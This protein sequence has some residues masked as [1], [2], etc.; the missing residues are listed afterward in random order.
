M[1]KLNRVNRDTH[2]THITFFL[3]K[4]K[5]QIK[6]SRKKTDSYPEQK[7]HFSNDVP[8]AKARRSKASVIR[9]KYRRTN[10][11]SHF[12]LP[13]CGSKRD[14]CWVLTSPEYRT[15]RPHDFGGGGGSQRSVIP[16]GEFHGG[17]TRNLVARRVPRRVAGAKD[18][19]A[20]I[21]PNR[22]PL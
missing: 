2:H 21:L 22:I 6:S 10:Q 14:S 20:E 16:L 1:L 17:W 3:K 15:D 19:R 18:G 12:P 5:E 7:F 4:K 8:I 11:T 9:A 13:R